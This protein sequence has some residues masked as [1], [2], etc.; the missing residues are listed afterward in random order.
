MKINPLQMSIRSRKLGLLIH[1]ARMATRRSV[2]ECSQAIGVTP[3]VFNEYELGEKSPSLPE[4]E[5]L[6][7]YVNVPLEHFWG[8]EMLPVD[9]ERS[10]NIDPE[11]VRSLRQRVIGLMLRKARVEAGVSPDELAERTSITAEKIEAY[12]MGDIPV[13]VPELE[14]I[15]SA[16]NIPIR[17]MYDQHGPVGTWASQQQLLRAFME[18][19]PEIQAFVCKPIN[20]P[21]ISVAER[22]SEMSVEKLRAVAEGLL[23]IT[24]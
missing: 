13:P 3:Q 11:R 21:Y 23:E 5:L 4:L 9:G 10:R 1:N 12:E 7:F 18:L 22:L 2:E 8:G 24:L 19:P 20:R 17:S 14:V 6:A 15:S 16:L